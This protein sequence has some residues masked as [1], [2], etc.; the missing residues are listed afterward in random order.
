MHLVHCVNVVTYV[1]R[2]VNVTIVLIIIKNSFHGDVYMY[3]IK[4]YNSVRQYN[5]IMMTNHIQ[6][7][8]TCVF[9]HSSSLVISKPRKKS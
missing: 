8:L 4:L 3:D 7:Y 5:I 6:I 9:I 2:G 1:L